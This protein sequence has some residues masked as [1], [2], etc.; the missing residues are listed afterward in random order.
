M[1]KTNEKIYNLL[2]IILKALVF[3]PLAYLFIAVLFCHNTIS[4]D[5]L[6][7]STIVKNG[8][9]FFA[10]LLVGILL[11]YGLYKI[12]KCVP[13]TLLFVILAGVYILAGSF[14]FLNM[15]TVLRYDS[16]ICYWN[17][18]NYIENNYVNMQPG[19]YFYMWPHQLGLV[20]YNCI[21]TWISNDLN[22]VY[23]LNLFWVILTNLFVWMSARLVYKEN[24]VLRKMIIVFCFAF[25]PQFFYSFYAYGQVPGLCF[26]MGAL[27][28]VIYYIKEERKWMLIPTIIFMSAACVIA[29]NFAVGG[30]AIIIILLFHILKDK[31]WY[32]L[33]IIIGI[34]VSMIV[35]SRLV[36]AHYERV[37]DADLSQGM[38]AMLY[39]AMGLQENEDGVWRANGWYNGYSEEIYRAS[40]CDVKQSNELAKASIRDS[41]NAFA[42]EPLYAWEFFE[43][44]IVTT[45]CEPTYQSVWSGPMIVMGSTTDVA[46]IEDLY[47]GGITFERLIVVMNILVAF[48]FGFSL[49]H[50]VAQTIT[51]QDKM[52]MLELFGLLF[53]YGG[54]IFHLFWETKSRYVYFYVFML[55]PI[56]CRGVVDTFAYMEQ[57]LIRLNNSKNEEGMNKK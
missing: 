3:L 19:E 28:S 30:I 33:F 47:S 41:I 20:S 13:E 10:G 11:L 18:A 40:N 16:G 39:V 7:L 25:L 56:A 54:F 9:I 12:L 36:I 5:I 14:L 44:K 46:I 4:F 1:K 48:V 35:P 42:S 55:M 34:I 29:P 37:A 51:K 45:W 57:K 24:V 43:E 6:E 21:L 2:E 15:E 38:P 32:G 23:F 22:L 27:W 53:F 26:L 31:K 8:P 49:V 17:A 52:T 50:I